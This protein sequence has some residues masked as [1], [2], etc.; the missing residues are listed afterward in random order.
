MIAHR[1]YISIEHSYASRANSFANDPRAKRT[2]WVVLEKVHG[3]NF[4]FSTDG[5]DLVCSKRSAPLAEHEPFYGWQDVRERH[6]EV[7]TTC[8]R[9]MRERGML[10][11]PD[12]GSAEPVPPTVTIYGE[13]FGG[14]YA[15][16]SLPDPPV[17]TTAVQREVQ[18]SPRNEFLAFDLHDGR[19]F[20]DY[21]MMAE[22]LEATGVPYLRP[23]RTCSLND[24]LRYNPRF[25]TTIPQL[26]GLPRIAGNMA[27]GV[28]IRPV[29]ELM[30]TGGQRM[31]L[32][33]K[34]DEFSERVEAMGKDTKKQWRA[35]K[36]QQGRGGR[37]GS[38]SA[39]VAVMTPGEVVLEHVRGFVNRNRLIT[40]ASKHGEVNKK[41]V[42]R[43]T[44]MMA[45]DAWEEVGRER[46]WADK[47]ATLEA[48][49][50]ERVDRVVREWA[51][52]VGRDYLK[53]R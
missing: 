44:E 20:L 42:A 8:W 32:K 7:V 28:V 33:I 12:P 5:L 18:Y 36:Q 10:P 27:E 50:R 9:I 48:G 1:P 21:D 37:A 22:L 29:K 2:P 23:L 53:K 19:E 47:I 39:A 34:A 11:S 24:A 26:L 14:L 52:E 4:A 43:M 40:M 49:E 35:A 45:E 38:G 51:G 46:A 3:A 16:P 17:D 41:N 13:L 15:H 31:I 30:A 25:E 6:R